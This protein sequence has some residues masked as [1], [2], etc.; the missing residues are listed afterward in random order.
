[1]IARKILGKGI[2]AGIAIAVSAPVQANDVKLPSTVAWS[3]YAVGSAAYGQAVA[4]GKT[5]QDEYNV[6][7]RI[8]PAANDLARL[9]P[10]RDGRIPFSAAGS[11]LYFATEGLDAFASPE[12]GPQ[13]VRIMSSASADNCLAL[14]TAKDA[15]I[16]TF[17]DLKG[18]RIAW[19]L[20]APGLQTNIR[21]FL[22]FGGL[23]VDDVDLVEVPSYGA[24]WQGLANNQVDATTGLTTGG[25]IEQAAASPRGLHWLPMQFDNSAGWE[26]LSLVAPHMVQRRATVGVANVSKEAPLQCMA[27]PYPILVTYAER[28]T[29][30]VYN[31]TKAVSLQVPNFAKAEPSAIGWADDRQNFRWVVPFH[32]GAVRYWKERG[33]WSADDEAHNQKI[34]RRQAVLAEAWKKM[35]GEKGEDF[36]KKWLAVRA[37]ALQAEGLPVF[38]SGN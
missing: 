7:L 8:V 11:D 31:M 2:I 1:M 30:F 19:V 28:D 12:W 34:L 32:E 20:G 35:E 27:A 25:V 36:A 18:K 33:L 15:N 37:K 29:D 26:R 4:I 23:T 14:G 24:A 3:A 6:S 9:A 38:G 17:A 22:A 10:V 5:I 16:K 13:R 21:A